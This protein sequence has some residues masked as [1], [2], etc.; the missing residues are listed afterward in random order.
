[1]PPLLTW[2]L[3]SLY[4]LISLGVIGVLWLPMWWR[5]GLGRGAAGALTI[6]LCSTVVAL[7]V[8][9]YLDPQLRAQTFNG[10][11]PG[12]VFIAVLTAF[13]YHSLPLVC[14]G[15]TLVTALVLIVG[16]LEIHRARSHTETSDTDVQ[17][18]PSDDG[19]S[20]PL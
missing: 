13:I 1:M 20:Q 8:A 11:W 18:D 12:V 3:A 10:P 2:K 9:A 7:C 4:A 17:A 19:L 16:L 6:A 15:C 5:Y 14:Y